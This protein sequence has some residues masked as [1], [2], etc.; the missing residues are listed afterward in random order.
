MSDDKLDNLFRE[1]LSERNVAFNMESWRKMEQMLPAETKPAGFKFGKVAAAVGALFVISASVLVWNFSE[2]ETIDNNIVTSNVELKNSDNN[3]G[4]GLE[5]SVNSESSISE[6]K[7]EMSESPDSDKDFAVQNEELNQNESTSIK[8]N[9]VESESSSSSVNSSFVNSV[10]AIG[11]RSN[12]SNNSV[13]KTPVNY[14]T[15]NSN[16][17]NKF[18]ADNSGFAGMNIEKEESISFEKEDQIT[19]FST[20]EGLEEMETFTLE[21]REDHTLFAELGDSQLPRVKRNEIGFIGGVNLSRELV[22]SSSK[23]ISGCEFLGVSYKRYLNGG[24]SVSADILYAPRNEVNSV[25]N[26]GKKVY[27]FGSVVEQTSVSSERLIY[28]E[29]PLLLTYNLGNHNFMAGP[30]FGYLVTGKHQVSTTYTTQTESFIENN[31]QWGNTNG[32]NR[33][34]FALVGGY[35]FNFNPK[36]NVGLRLNYGLTDVTNNDYFGT[37]SFDNNVQL[38]VYLKYVPFNF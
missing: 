26:Y 3:S 12:S 11:T 21:E 8:A 27:G 36:W 22:E 19:A 24:L 33:F 7:V 37:D 34:D 4:N 2:D 18:F 17:S 29:M 15:S 30:S 25:K 9:H 32:Y 10:N 31:T 16:Q 23:G 35:E 20:I 13:S 14:K 5:T 38:R 28:L 6:S 1:G